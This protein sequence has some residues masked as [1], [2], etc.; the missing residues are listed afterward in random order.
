VGFT[1]DAALAAVKSMRDVKG[2]GFD[3]GAAM[4][5]LAHPATITG[6]VEIGGVAAFA[7][8]GGLFVA[9]LTAARRGAGRGLAAEPADRPGGRSGV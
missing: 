6:W 9:A 1:L 5:R 7:V 8:I 3:L 2:T 4:G